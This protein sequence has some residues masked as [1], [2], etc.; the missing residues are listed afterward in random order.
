MSN[1]SH[2]V[3]H[4]KDVPE[5]EVEGAKGLYRR[6]LISRE[7]GA[8]NFA[9]RLFRMAPGGRS[10]HHSHDW[11][12]EVFVLSGRGRANVGGM[13][14][15]LYP[16]VFLFIPAGVDHSFENVGGEDLLFLCM[17]PI[18]SVPPQR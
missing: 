8:P 14:Y 2:K 13:T 3:A 10:A 9:M 16:G 7:D 15:D 6:W 1:V 17:V 5:E 18:R 12:H 4:W 11:E